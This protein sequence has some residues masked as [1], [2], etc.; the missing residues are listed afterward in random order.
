MRPLRRLWRG[1]RN[2]DHPKDTAPAEEEVGYN[3]QRD[4]YLYWRT[5]EG[6]II[7]QDVTCQYDYVQNSCCAECGGSLRIAAHLNR[8]GQGLSELVA[9][10]ENCRA[11]AN[12]IFDI[13]NDVYQTWWEA[14]LGALYVRQYDGDPRTPLSPE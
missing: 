5:E 9:L 4:D 14:E 13:S 1:K 11:R 6:Y 12:F 7:A 10:C 3:T 2:E 8:A